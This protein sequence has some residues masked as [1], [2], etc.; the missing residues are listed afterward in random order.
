[1]IRVMIAAGVL[2]A[3]FAYAYA[4]A[5]GAHSSEAAGGWTQ[6][7]I[8]D[9]ISAFGAY[10]GGGLALIA[11]LFTVRE[12]RKL[13]LWEKFRDARRDAED[14]K[15]MQGIRLALENLIV[16]AETDIAR[17]TSDGWEERV[18]LNSFRWLE[19][20][21]TA[22][23]RPAFDPFFFMTYE[24]TAKD[25]EEF[26]G[27]FLVYAQAGDVANMRILLTDRLPRIR[28]FMVG[29]RDEALRGERAGYAH[30]KSW[31]AMAPA[32]M[33]LSLGLR[34]REAPE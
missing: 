18:Q 26:K 7:W 2:A 17:F 14:F 10:F 22:T 20:N 21:R 28:N 12:M 31:N 32:D 3:G 27:D 13:L 30:V 24:A 29:L 15:L 5:T 16:R 8:R 34:E 1:M 6:Q 4:V 11:A 19:L 25:I 9:W 23:I 33:Q